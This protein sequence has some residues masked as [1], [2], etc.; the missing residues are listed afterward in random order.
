LFSQK[1]D[2]NIFDSSI[3]SFFAAKSIRQTNLTIKDSFDLL[4]YYSQFIYC[5]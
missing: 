5:S 2:L 1:T 4:Q 3:N